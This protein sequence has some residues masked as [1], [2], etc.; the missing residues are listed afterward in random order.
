LLI[1][2]Y[3]NIHSVMN[4]TDIK[5]TITLSNGTEMPY[6]GLGVFE[7]REGTETLN[8]IQCALETGYRHIDTA[9]LYRNEKSVGDAILSSGI[10]REEIFITTKVWNSDQGYQ[11]TMNAF[12]R[13]L[14]KLQ[15]GYVDLYLV[16]WPVLGKYSDTWK[17]LEELYRQNLVHTIG[18]SNFNQ[19]HLE[20]LMS[21]ADIMP[22]VNQ[23]EF[24]PYLS[25]PKLRGFCSKNGIQYEAWAPLMRGQLTKV[26]E[27]ESITLKYGK[28][29][30]QIILRWDLQKDVITIPKSVHKER[31][32]SNA[33]IFD[34]QLSDDD[35]LLIDSLDRGERIGANPDNFDF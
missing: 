28:T 14:N 19:H 24:H 2:K 4:I 35:I 32:I 15:T 22:M 12:Q 26:E 10:K 3:E 29:P 6:F 21:H 8:A 18:V 27:L 30:A 9:T 25:Q 7:V 16:H 1:I 13:S 5:G 33:D 31:I 17:A 34:F 23:M 20:N 11:N